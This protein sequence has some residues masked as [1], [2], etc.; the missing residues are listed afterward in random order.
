MLGNLRKKPSS[1]S[2][3]VN[4]EMHKSDQL[5]HLLFSAFFQ[6]QK[7]LRIARLL[8]PLFNLQQIFTNSEDLSTTSNNTPDSPPYY[9]G[10]KSTCEPCFMHNTRY[11]VSPG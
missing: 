10:S 3:F 1:T 9:H 11:S 2:P 4:L 7:L 8:P 5:L 6:E